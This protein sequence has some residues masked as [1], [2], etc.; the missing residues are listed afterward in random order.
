MR[1]DPSCYLRRRSSKA[2]L[3]AH[4]EHLHG[5]GGTEGDLSCIAGSS[6]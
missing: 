4:R 1:L 5:R 3:E 2:K 6:S